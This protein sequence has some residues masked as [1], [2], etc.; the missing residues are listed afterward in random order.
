M[1]YTEFERNIF[2]RSELLLGRESMDKLQAARVIVFGVGGVGSWCTEAL[3]RAGIR[4]IT[5]V[6]SDNVSASNLNRQLMATSETI[7]RVKVDALRERLLEIDPDA[8]ITAVCKIYSAGNAAEFD[9]DSYDYVIDCI[10]SLKD[11]I[12]LI[13]NATASRAVF[14]SAMGAALKLDPTK[15]RVAEFW[16]VRGCPLG[17]MLRKRMRQNGTLPSKHF[18]CVYDEEVLENK[19]TGHTAG[20][21]ITSFRKASINGSLAHITGI[22]GFT[23]AGLVISDIVK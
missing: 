4:H 9:L 1:A 23:L 20:K 18:L 21:E 22:F 16:N 7:G 6:D 12:T 10:D 8:E 3:L 15:I 14:F 11:K 17:S 19:G 5:I 2:N 13:L